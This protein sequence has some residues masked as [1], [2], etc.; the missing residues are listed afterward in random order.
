MANMQRT[1]D[2]KE[3]TEKARQAL[4]MLAEKQS[5]DKSEKGSKSDVIQAVKEDIKAMLEKGYTAQQVAEAFK[6]D[7]FSILPKS[8]TELVSSKKKPVR[9]S[10]NKKTNSESTNSATNQ[11][12]NVTTTKKQKANN[13][14]AGTF[15][16][17]PDSEDI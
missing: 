3:Y 4:K 7:V 6:N 12:T 17:K 5:P 1:F 10:G 11:A 15:A 8:I 16:V 14:A 9:K 2:I 13:E